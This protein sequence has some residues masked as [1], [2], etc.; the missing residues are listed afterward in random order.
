MTVNGI[1]VYFPSVVFFTVLYIFSLWLICER[2][3]AQMFISNE[4]NKTMSM[5]VTQNYSNLTITLR[6]IHFGFSELTDTITSARA[7]SYFDAHGSALTAH[8]KSMKY[9]ALGW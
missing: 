6:T 2:S 7:L 9:F 5:S 8:P 4:N 3:N 1:L